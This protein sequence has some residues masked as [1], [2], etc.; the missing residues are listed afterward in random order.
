MDTSCAATPIGYSADFGS[1][2]PS[3]GD[4]AGNPLAAAPKP[5]SLGHRT[6][7]VKH[8]CTASTI[9]ESL[10]G[11]DRVAAF[12]AELLISY[13]PVGVAEEQLV[14]QV[15]VHL[16]AMDLSAAAEVS[17]IRTVVNQNETLQRILRTPG[18]EG[19]GGCTCPSAEVPCP[20]CRDRTDASLMAAVASEPMSRIGKYAITHQRGANHTLRLLEQLQSKRRQAATL[21]VAANNVDGV[22]P[23]WTD[24]NVWLPATT[25]EDCAGFFLRWHRTRRIPCPNCD[26]T[27]TP[28]SIANRNALRCSKCRCQYGLRHGTPL[29]DSKLPLL[30]WLRAIRLLAAD[31]KASVAAIATAGGNIS[32]RA[33]RRVKKVTLQAFEDPASR[34]DVCALSGMRFTRRTPRF[35]NK[36]R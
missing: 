21:R 12:A 23:P 14:H 8:G 6:N 11:P 10:V 31:P 2:Q 17:A 35:P 25:E 29:A 34:E 20:Y 30:A 22:T 32:K 3:N 15:A 1:A 19:S 18:G 27:A 7:D 26:A 16:A 24:E 5:A 28:I 13:A 33:A 9:V 4:G 36:P